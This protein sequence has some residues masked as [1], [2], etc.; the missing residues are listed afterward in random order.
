MTDA[1]RSSLP[2]NMYPWK[3]FLPILHEF[4]KH[5]FVLCVFRLLGRESFVKIGIKPRAHCFQGLKTKTFKNTYHL[6]VKTLVRTIDFLLAFRFGLHGLTSPLKIV[7][8]RQ[9]ILQHI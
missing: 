1:A 8:D 4:L 5:R 6:T 9:E 2:S 3:E 7:E